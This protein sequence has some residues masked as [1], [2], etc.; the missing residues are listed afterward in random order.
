MTGAEQQN[1]GW[2]AAVLGL[3]ACRGPV[4]STAAHRSPLGSPQSPPPAC[5]PW[6]A[7]PRV[8]SSRPSLSIAH[9]GHRSVTPP[10]PT[11]P[12]PSCLPVAARTA[13]PGD[14]IEFTLSDLTC[15]PV[16]ILAFRMIHNC[17]DYKNWGVETIL[18][19]LPPTPSCV[20]SRLT[21]VPC[22]AAHSSQH[23]SAP[24]PWP[25]LAPHGQ[26]AAEQ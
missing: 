14:V 8:T 10:Q 16:K 22:R 24:Q 2:G 9:S 3:A 13:A 4:L 20:C 12:L 19:V 1:K 23:N 18:P 25:S 26:S 15:Y 6:G 21:A 17:F 5:F 11:A 7:G